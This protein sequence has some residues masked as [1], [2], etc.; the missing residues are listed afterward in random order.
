MSRT[1]SKRVLTLLLLV[2]LNQLTFDFLL[3]VMLQL[4]HGVDHL[5]TVSG[6]VHRDLKSDNALVAGLA[7]LSVKWGDFGCAVKLGRDT[8]Y[9][10]G[11]HY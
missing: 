11:S 5:H 3:A 4:A 8:S 9:G 7:P 10:P 1:S 2:V 6:V